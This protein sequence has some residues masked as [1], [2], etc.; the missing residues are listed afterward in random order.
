[1]FVEDIDLLDGPTLTVIPRRFQ[2]NPNATIEV[3]LF[4][5]HDDSS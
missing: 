1:V 5:A 2:L 4:A 3:S